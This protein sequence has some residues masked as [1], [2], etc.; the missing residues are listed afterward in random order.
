MQVFEKRV[1]RATPGFIA[2]LKSEN[3]GGLVSMAGSC[4]FIVGGDS[5]GLLVT[6][7]FICA[8]IVLARYGHYRS[9]YSI[10][11]LLFSIGDVLAINSEVAKGNHEFQ[12]VLGIMAT[13]WA[14]GALRSPIAWYAERFK[15][16]YWMVVAD[17]LQPLIGTTTLILR[18]PG[19]ITAFVG[20]NY[21][22][23]IAVA[24]W[25]A[26]DILVGRLQYSAQDAL[27]RIKSVD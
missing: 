6:F 23:G 8:E 16:P 1:A 20:G 21:L 2:D 7:S 12:I 18:I 11:C 25:A 19:L 14:L 10:G 5:S 4:L 9:G 22:G 24:C 17:G 15:R 26:S 27:R 13:V 3:V